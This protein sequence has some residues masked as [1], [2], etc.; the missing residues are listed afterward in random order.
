MTREQILQNK[1]FR[2]IHDGVCPRCGGE[3]KRDKFLSFSYPEVNE[4]QGCG[5]TVTA[6]QMEEM[7]GAVVEWGKEA[8]A[9]FE[10]N[11]KMPWAV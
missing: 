8:V 3:V 11:F 7:R 5:F 2:A 9:Y 1:I 10:K 4:C 6:E